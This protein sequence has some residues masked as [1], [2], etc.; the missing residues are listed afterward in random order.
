ML[1]SATQREEGAHALDLCQSDIE[2][3]QTAPTGNYPGRALRGEAKA[4]RLAAG[5]SSLVETRTQ[6]GSERHK[7]GSDTSALGAVLPS[8]LK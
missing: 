5:G 7:Q 3:D 1:L 8:D 6:I 2:R 4:D